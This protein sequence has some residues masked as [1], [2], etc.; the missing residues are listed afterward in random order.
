MPTDEVTA[1][2]KIVTQDHACQTVP[3]PHGGPHRPSSNDRAR[4]GKVTLH[5]NSDPQTQSNSWLTTC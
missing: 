4:K 5:E 3:R 1:P 2:L